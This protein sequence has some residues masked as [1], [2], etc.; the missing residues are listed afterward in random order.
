MEVR[1]ILSALI[2]ALLAC[3][4][5]AG[6]KSIFDEDWVPPRAPERTTAKPTPATKPAPA[7]PASVP[8]ITPSP[9]STASARLPIPSTLEQ[10]AV[11]KV[12]KEVYA[13]QL[14]DRS[15]AGRKK[16]AG[17]LQAQ[18]SKSAQLPVERFVLL[19]AAHDAAIEAND[20]PL[21][22][23]LADE[24]GRFYT[25]DALRVKAAAIITL[26]ARTSPENIRTSLGIAGELIR[27]DDYATATRICQAILPAASQA[28]QRAQIQNRLKDLSVLSEAEVSLS[29]AL[30]KLKT[31]S[32]DVAA[33]LEV[34]R[35]YC[36]LKNDWKA[37]LP[38]LAKGFDPELKA[39][40]AEELAAPASPA[41]LAQLAGSWWEI[42]NRQTD[43]ISKAAATAHAAMLYQAAR[44]GL[45]GLQSQLAQKRIADA[46][47]IVAASIHAIPRN[48]E[49]D[50]PPGAISL[51]DGKTTENWSGDPA[52]WSV[53]DGAIR[54]AST[55]KDSS[56]LW[57]KTSF[58]DFRFEAQFKFL[59]G[60][61]GIIFRGKSGEK[62]SLTSG[63]EADIFLPNALGKL[64]YND[65]VIFR[66]AKPLQDRVYKPKEWN[67]YT[68]EVAGDHM[69]LWI[70]GE[71]MT[72]VTH[73]GDR[74][75]L[76]ALQIAGEG[77]EVFF[78]E[79][80]LTA[81]GHAKAQADFSP[82]GE[83]VKIDTGTRFII[84][85]DG[86]IH[87]PAGDIYANGHWTATS[88]HKVLL[89]YPGGQSCTLTQDA[90]GRLTGRMT[91]RRELW[92]LRRE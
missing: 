38:H 21:A 45:T 92:S 68:I 10:A 4:A 31:N 53:A 61:T 57:H 66:P 16:L 47:E 59:K 75:G 88:D 34:G 90:E 50:G 17:T 30:E 24:L 86:T 62:F 25:V 82:V 79:L 85:E 63:Y 13:E 32:D 89:K 27:N 23:S 56:F 44:P 22:L 67:Q 9:A 6:P 80:R 71:L 37:G 5:Q 42:A 3:S 87:A 72:D 51:F 73:N 60:N 29:K 70:N 64:A 91:P 39:L 52:V 41:A 40:A 81:L 83:W 78:R 20:L 1:L 35:N 58:A 43:S 26:A 55:R 74:T 76:I 14:V 69:R 2:M 49:S 8:A 46:A 48:S 15:A 28:D 65:A 36:F 84:R 11:R 33:H 77:G 7:T 12:M 18:A 19:V 54:G